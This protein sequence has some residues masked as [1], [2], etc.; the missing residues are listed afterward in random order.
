MRSFT[1]RRLWIAVIVFVFRWMPL[2]SLVISIMLGSAHF[3]EVA[4]L[5]LTNTCDD[6]STH[7][8]RIRLITAPPLERLRCT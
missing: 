5:L 8:A 4:V 7:M 1:R 2:L 3:A 6:G